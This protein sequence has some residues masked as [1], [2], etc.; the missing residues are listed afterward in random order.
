MCIFI[1]L[2]TEYCKGNAFTVT[3][4]YFPWMWRLLLLFPSPS[5]F[6][7]SSFGCTVVVQIE[8]FLYFTEKRSHEKCLLW[9]CFWQGWNITDFLHVA[10]TTVSVHHALICTDRKSL[11]VFKML[12]L[13]LFFHFMAVFWL[14]F[15]YKSLLFPSHPSS[16]SPPTGTRWEV[17]GVTCRG[18]GLLLLACQCLITHTHTHTHSNHCWMDENFDLFRSLSLIWKTCSQR[19]LLQRPPCCYLN[20]TCSPSEFRLFLSDS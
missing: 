14:K 5:L 19:K 3:V 8:L 2:L 4:L 18:S 6:F 12:Y 20:Q 15:A 1:Y 11:K 7:A 9:V 13:S 10:V 16:F 17:K